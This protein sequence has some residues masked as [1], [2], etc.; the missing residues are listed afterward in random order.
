MMSPMTGPAPSSEADRLPAD[1]PAWAYMLR[2][3]DGSLYSGWTN[4]LARR[5]R[6]HN[7]GGHGAR[8][9]RAHGGGT[10]AYAQ[11]CADRSAAMRREAALKKLSK[12][13]KEALA[14]AW[15]A[16]NKITIRPA[17]PEDAEAINELYGW[18]VGHSTATYQYIRPTVEETRADLCLALEKAAFVVAVDGA[19][20]LAGYACAHPW[21]TREAFAW[22]AETTVYCD[23]HRLS[24]GVGKRLYTAVLEILKAK[25]YWNAIALVADPNPASAAFHKAMGFTRY[26]REPRTG[27]K[28]G[29]WLGLDYWVLPLRQGS[30]APEPV[31]YAL[32]LEE[33]DAILR[34]ANGEN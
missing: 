2:C 19:G 15:A 12:A 16:E 3:A 34:R 11:R 1:P 22:D 33:L 5:L 20:K 25:G 23:P 14:A 13:E 26:G 4:D 27:Y 28:F 8:Y 18:Y 6:A 30:D 29:Q 7:G 21:H 32:P 10:L 31:R 24:L 17:A 9:T